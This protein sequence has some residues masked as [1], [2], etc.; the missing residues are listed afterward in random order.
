MKNMRAGGTLELL[1]YRGAF[2]QI[3]LPTSN[4]L[5]R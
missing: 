4:I 3:V 1:T 5:I 2:H